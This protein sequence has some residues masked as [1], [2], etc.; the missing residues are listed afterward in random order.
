M[1]GE[2]LQTAGVFNSYLEKCDCKERTG[3]TCRV[4]RGL[5][6]FWGGGMVPLVEEML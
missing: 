2:E 6:V 3:S 5:F 4:K 1:R